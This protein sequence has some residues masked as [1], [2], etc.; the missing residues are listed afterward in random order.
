MNRLIGVVSALLLGLVILVPA[1]AEPLVVWIVGGAIEIGSA[2]VAGA[3][4]PSASVLICAPSTS[5]SGA[6]PL[7]STA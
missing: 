6:T 1:V 3:P 7:F 5:T 4:R 2:T